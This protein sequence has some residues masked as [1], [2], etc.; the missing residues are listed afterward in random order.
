MAMHPLL[1]LTDIF[2]RL[3]L[4]IWSRYLIFVK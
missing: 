3:I 4:E 2:F 1:I